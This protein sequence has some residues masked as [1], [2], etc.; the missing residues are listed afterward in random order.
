MIHHPMI[1][2][3]KLALLILLAVVLV[4]LHG[5]LPPAQFRV[6]VV[7]SIALFVLLSIVIWIVAFRL[8]QNPNSKLHQQM[9]LSTQQRAEDGY[10]AAGDGY[11]DL[12]GKCGVA[13]T[14]LRP[15]G[16]AAFDGKRVS[17]VS[18]GEFIPSGSRVEVIE[19]K[20][21]RVVVRPAT[22]SSD[23]QGKSMS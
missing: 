21:S 7:L 1:L 22:V 18:D 9:V 11:G 4:I 5:V 23:E 3:P 6:A 13:V 15:A 19:V 10:R 14:I 16:T 12:V 17:V 20:G 2:G 8:L